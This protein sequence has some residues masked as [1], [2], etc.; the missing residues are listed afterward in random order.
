MGLAPIQTPPQKTE[1]LRTW[2]RPGDGADDGAEPCAEVASAL[3]AAP[4][5]R[6]VTLGTWIVGGIALFFVGF[7]LT[8]ALQLDAAAVVGDPADDEPVLVNPVAARNAVLELE[9]ESRKP[10]AQALA[11]KR[12]VAENDESNAARPRERVRQHP[13]GK[14]RDRV[15]LD[16]LGRPHGEYSSF[17]PNGATWETGSFEHGAKVGTWRAYHENGQLRDEGEFE[18]G[19]AEGLARL[20]DA[21]GHLVREMTMHG[22]AEGPASTWYANGQLESQGGYSN[23]RRE[24]EWKFWLPDGT[25]DASRAGNYSGDHKLDG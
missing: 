11:G 3:D 2:S 15:Q 18:S 10:S 7:A 17:H 6:R 5:V 23:G 12:A 14:P 20:W 24:G 8:L 13:N 4:G 9:G 19:R 25:L 1:L 16:E 21:E 22:Q